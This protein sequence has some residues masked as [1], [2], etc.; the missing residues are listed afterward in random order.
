MQIGNTKEGE[1]GG[2]N[3][4]QNGFKTRPITINDLWASRQLRQNKTPNYLCF[5]PSRLIRQETQQFVR[6]GIFL[7]FLNLE[8]IYYG[9]PFCKDI[10]QGNNQCCQHDFT[11]PFLPLI[12]HKAQRNSDQETQPGCQVWGVIVHLQSK[13]SDFLSLV[14]TVSFVSMISH[15]LLEEPQFSYVATKAM[16]QPYTITRNLKI[17]LFSAKCTS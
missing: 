4:T 9:R 16:H 6:Q 11:W 14:V 3:F 7:M 10:R 5:P 13:E 8:R 1:H 17:L 12:A 2:E 15:L